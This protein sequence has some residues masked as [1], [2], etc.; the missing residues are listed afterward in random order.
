MCL[1]RYFVHSRFPIEPKHGRNL[2]A[3]NANEIFVPVLPLFEEI[4]SDALPQTSAA[5]P[6]PVVVVDGDASES[7]SRVIL[8]SADLHQF[9]AEESRSLKE[10]LGK[11]Q[12]DGTSLTYPSRDT[13]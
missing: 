3:I 1:N 12:S 9:L 2:G 8:R 4:P 13:D 11:V 6:A 10:Q 7:E 5:S